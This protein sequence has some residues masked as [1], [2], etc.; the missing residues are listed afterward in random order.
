MMT[1]RSGPLSCGGHGL[2]NWAA[3]T[4]GVGQRQ[5]AMMTGDELAQGDVADRRLAHVTDN[6]DLRCHDDY[7][8]ARSLC[9]SPG[10]APRH[11]DDMCETTD[12][13]VQTTT[14]SDRHESS[15]HRQPQLMDLTLF[16]DDDTH[17]TLCV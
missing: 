4:T 6:D 16:D 15:Y 5:T 2:L 3:D 17:S 13:S 14:T 8:D 1:L 10:G 12:V 9:H 11:N 7:Y